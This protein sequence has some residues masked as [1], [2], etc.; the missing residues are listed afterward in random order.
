MD[1][2]ECTEEQCIRKIQEML[3]VERIFIFQIIKEGDI[4]QLGLNLISLKEGSEWGWL[5]SNDS[6]S[7]AT[8]PP[9]GDLGG[10]SK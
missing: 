5:R 8:S 3:Q 2:Q 10:E 4:I 9:E 7:L 1:A 6:F